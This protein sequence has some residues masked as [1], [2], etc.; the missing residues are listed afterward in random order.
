M[1]LYFIDLQR[2]FNLISRDEKIARLP[3]GQT[4]G[5]PLGNLKEK[6]FIRFAHYGLR[7]PFAYER[8][9]STQIKNKA[10]PRQLAVKGFFFCRGEKTRTS[11]LHVPNVAR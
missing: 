4:R 5:L 7:F 1:P 11:D 9:L 10:L 3:L 8:K 6:A 2:S